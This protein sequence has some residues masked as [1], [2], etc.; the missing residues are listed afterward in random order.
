[1]LSKK[2]HARRYKDWWP[3]IV[4]AVMALLAVGGYALMHALVYLMPPQKDGMWL[5]ILLYLV[6]IGLGLATPYWML[7]WGVHSA[8][9]RDEEETEVRLKDVP[10]DEVKSK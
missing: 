8:H 1:M 6:I 5:Q 4:I 7:K 9:M 10:K 3:V 2:S